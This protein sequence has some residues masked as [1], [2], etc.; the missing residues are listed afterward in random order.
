M[1]NR[2][3]V[4]FGIG[5]FLLSIYSTATNLEGESIVPIYIIMLS[6]VASILFTILATVR[7]WKVNKFASSLF[8]IS[9]FML[10]GLE[11]MQSFHPPAYGS[12]IVISLNIVKV[13]RFVSFVWVLLLLWRNRLNFPNLQ[14][15]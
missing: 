4:I 6:G 11:I 8:V 13:V 2:A 9:S 7:L 14:L 5:T 10:F 15:Y 3:L 12:L 1:K